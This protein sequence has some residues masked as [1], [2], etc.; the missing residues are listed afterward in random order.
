MLKKDSLFT[1]MLMKYS[2]LYLMNVRITP[3][4][5]MFFALQLSYLTLFNNRLIHPVIAKI[6][7]N[8]I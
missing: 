5:D 8:L 2:N 6:L 3:A 7:E 4:D 1:D